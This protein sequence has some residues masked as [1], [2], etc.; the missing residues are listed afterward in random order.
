MFVVL[1]ESRTWTMVSTMVIPP[2]T[3]P[4]ALGMH[5]VK[6]AIAQRINLD[7]VRDHLNPHLAVKKTAYE[8]WDTLKNLYEAKNENQKMSLR[9]KLHGTKMA[10]GEG[11]VSYLTWVA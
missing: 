1:K 11:V 8:M 2:T 7:G 4:F 6:E 5:E 10:K 9:D 3:Y